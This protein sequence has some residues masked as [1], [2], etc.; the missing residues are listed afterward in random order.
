MGITCK[1]AVDFISKKE[2]GKLSVTQ[3]LNLWRHLMICRFCRLFQKQNRVITSSFADSNADEKILSEEDK[4]AIV[5][6]LQE[7]D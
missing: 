3:R 5:K 2:E 6:A 4:N 1:Q 7:A